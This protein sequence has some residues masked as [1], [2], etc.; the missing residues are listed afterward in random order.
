M[1]DTELVE[2]LREQL[3]QVRHKTTDIYQLQPFL[4]DII[5]RLNA[6]QL[7]WVCDVFF[8]AVSV[9]VE[10][11]EPKVEVIDDSEFDDDPEREDTLT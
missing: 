7:Y 6:R 2:K 10:K 5:L 8:T 11:P 4:L 9:G 3:L 1:K